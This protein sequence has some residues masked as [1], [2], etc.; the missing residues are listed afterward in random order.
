MRTEPSKRKTI[1]QKEQL[2][3]SPGNRVGR[4]AERTI[5]EKIHIPSST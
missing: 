3:D 5:R 1:P 2:A 4:D